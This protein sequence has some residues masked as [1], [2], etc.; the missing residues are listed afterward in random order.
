[1]EHFIYLTF[2]LFQADALDLDILKLRAV[3]TCYQGA[4]C[5]SKV[6]TYLSP[7]HH[8]V[9]LI[10]LHYLEGDTTRKNLVLNK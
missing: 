1:M 6:S 4:L 7:F 3:A 2:S 8:G 10:I 5:V 9:G